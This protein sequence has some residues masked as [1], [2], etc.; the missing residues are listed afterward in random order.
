LAN[1][2]PILEN[3][4]LIRKLV[5]IA[6]F[7]D[8]ELMNTFVLKGGNAIAIIYGIND[9][10]SI[11]ID[12]SMEQDFK[13]EK[14]EEI[15]T[16]LEKSLIK[17]FDDYSYLV[18]DVNLRPKPKT[19]YKETKDFWGGYILEFKV[20]EKDK[21]QN[22]S[23]EKRRKQA[24]PIGPKKRNTF[25]VDISKFEYCE[26]KTEKELDGYT[27]YVYTPLMVVYEKL[28]AICQQLPEYTN[29]IR[30]KSRPRARDFFDIY[31]IVTALE[32][33]SQLL[34]P[35]N[36]EILKAM[37][38]AKQVPIELLFQISDQKEFHAENFHAVKDTVS[39][40][41]NLQDYDFYFDY[42]L[43]LT[44]NLKSSGII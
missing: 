35:A 5:V 37:F 27:I 30:Q 39:D 3:L 29:K 34:D 13:P 43:N 4:K 8:D 26:P 10:A 17:T 1:Q 32:L 18:F 12:V 28:R 36:L 2:Q 23:I 16:K 40:K 41:A 15:R 11:D 42:V 9:R 22:L 31:S 24:L 33:K 44:E 25:K 6:M 38:A 21:G 14:L 19:P 20:I 7:A